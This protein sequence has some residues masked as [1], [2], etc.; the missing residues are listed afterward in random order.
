MRCEDMKVECFYTELEKVKPK[1]DPVKDKI[2]WKALSNQITIDREI[3][4]YYVNDID[5]V[6]MG[7]R[8]YSD[9]PSIFSEYYEKGLFTIE[10]LNARPCVAVMM[11]Y[12]DEIPKDSIRFNGLGSEATME[13]LDLLI[14]DDRF[15]T[16]E[17]IER[18][19]KSNYGD[20][21]EQFR[22]RALE[23]YKNSLPF[24][25]WGKV[26]KGQSIGY[27]DNWFN[28]DEVMKYFNI[29]QPLHRREVLKRMSRENLEKYQDLFDF[30]TKELIEQRQLWHTRDILKYF[31]TGKFRARS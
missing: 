19:L 25:I 26:E 7:A 12:W 8:L 5:W 9:N 29:S 28:H 31:F 18:I 1:I 10:S 2:N 11:K 27:I 14:E 30:T 4:N 21:T 22:K 6:V 3:L 23:V 20:Y 17:V 24:A 16:E 15:T 13:V